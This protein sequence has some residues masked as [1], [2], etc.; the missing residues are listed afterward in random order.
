MVLTAL[1]PEPAETPMAFWATMSLATR[2]P[3][4][5]ERPAPVLPRESESETIE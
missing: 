3:A 5:S 2:L 1:R 4:P